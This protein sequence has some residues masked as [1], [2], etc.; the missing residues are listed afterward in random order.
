MRF[1]LRYGA[2]N[3]TFVHCKCVMHINYFR[4]F[5]VNYF[6]SNLIKWPFISLF[7]AENTYK[8]YKLRQSFNLLPKIKKLTFL[9]SKNLDFLDWKV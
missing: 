6:L 5:F 3:M 9:H 7:Y 2:F 1:F 8:K 4:M